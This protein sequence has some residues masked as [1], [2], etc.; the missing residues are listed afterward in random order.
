MKIR[1][2]NEQEKRKMSAIENERRL[3]FMISNLNKAG[4]F[5]K[6][7]D[8]LP[9]KKRSKI[10]KTETTFPLKEATILLKDIESGLNKYLIR[11]NKNT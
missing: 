2:L 11:K 9:V 7:I 6:Y 10:V 1:G 3:G 4:V 8:T 5:V